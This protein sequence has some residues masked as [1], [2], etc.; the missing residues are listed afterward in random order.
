MELSTQM[1]LFDAIQKG[2]HFEILDE[3]DQ[4]LKL[5]HKNHV[6]YVKNGNMTSKDNYVVPLAMANKT[7]TKK[8]L[9]DAGF[10]VPAGDEF[11]SL[12]QGLAYYPLIKDKQ[13]VVKPK[14]T[15]FGLGISIFQ[16]PASGNRETSISKDFFGHGFISH[17]KRDYI[18]VF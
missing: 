16:E 5:W 13:I 17:G 14:S 3:Q 2:I 12:E 18:V 4:F 15:N 7:V 1:L 8:I 11:T 6:E 9:A 10:P